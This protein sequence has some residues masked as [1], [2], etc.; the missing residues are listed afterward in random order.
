VSGISLAF[1][2]D[3]DD[4]IEIVLKLFKEGSL[5]SK[6]ALQ[7]INDV[8]VRQPTSSSLRRTL[9]ERTVILVQPLPIQSELGRHR[10][11][12]ICGT[13]ITVL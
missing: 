8:T 2:A 13:S 9:L 11:L 7:I 3:A 6:R 1:H 4:D 10:A 12:E 5:C